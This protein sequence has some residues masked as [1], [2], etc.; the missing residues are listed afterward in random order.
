MAAWALVAKNALQAVEKYEKIVKAIDVAMM[1]S[2][3]GYA[4]CGRESA[5]MEAKVK[6]F[7]VPG[8]SYDNAVV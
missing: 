7:P 2:K 6:K 5:G 4:E 1:L 8:K 3:A